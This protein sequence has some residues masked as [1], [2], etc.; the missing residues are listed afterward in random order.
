MSTLSTT[1]RR[2]L[3]VTAAAMAAGPV[4]GGVASAATGP[5]TSA[6]LDAAPITSTAADAAQLATTPLPVTRSALPLA[7]GLGSVMPINGDLAGPV[8]GLTSG[9]PLNNIAGG[10]PVSGLAGQLPVVGPMAKNLPV[11]SG[12]TGEPAPT[13]PE[14]AAVAQKAASDLKADFPTPHMPTP[15]A[16]MTPAHAATRSRPVAP[17]GPAGPVA[18]VAPSVSA[19]TQAEQAAAAKA[20]A[21]ATKPSTSLPLVGQLP[22]GNLP[23]VGGL[24]QGLPVGNVTGLLGAF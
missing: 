15:P 18:P 1:V 19:P 10:L 24:T 5:T 17:A 22:T 20:A 13:T 12:L 14:A 21:A 2:G 6:P 8:S 3:V 11:V 7:G 4:V 9:V 16:L 23:V